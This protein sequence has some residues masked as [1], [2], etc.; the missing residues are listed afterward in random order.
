LILNNPV[1]SNNYGDPFRTPLFIN[2]E[3][4]IKVSA[5]AVSIGTKNASISLF[6]NG[7]KKIETNSDSL[8]YKFTV[9]EKSN[10][11]TIAGKDTANSTDTVEFAVLVNPPIK[12][13]HLP[14]NNE[15]GINYNSNTSVTLALFAPYK[16]FVYLIGDF[17][18]W[19]VDTAYFMKKDSVKADSV[20]WWLTINNL[21]PG[22]EYSF[23]YFVDGNLR[24][25]D[26]FSTKVL[27]PANDQYISNTVYPNLKPYPYNKTSEIVSVLET[28][29]PVYNWK[30]TSFKKP[31]KSNLI[32]Y[33][34][35]VRDFVSTR[36]FKTVEDTLS[37]LKRLGVNAIEF[38]PVMEFE[39]N[40]SWGYNPDFQMALDKYYGTPDAFKS[41]IDKAHSMGIA[42][43]LDIVLNH[44]Y[45]QSPLARL[46]WDTS[47]NRPAA[48][49]PWFN[50]VSPNP[51]YSFGNDFNHES[52][53]TKYFID[54]VNKYWI[55]EY[56]A[57]GFR[58]DFAKG[59]T[60]TY[61][62]GT[63]YDSKRIA[64]MQRMAEKIW[65]IDSTSILILENFVDNAEEKVESGFGFLSWG[66][67]NYNYNEATMGYNQPGHSDL[68]NAYF[69]FR[70]WPKPSLVSY[71]ESHDEERLMYKNEQY[72]NHSPYYNVKLISNGLKRMGEAAAFFLT[73]PGPKMI[74]QFGELGYDYSINYPSL[75]S[76]DRLTAKPVKWEYFN[77]PERQRLYKIFAAIIKLRNSNPV[78]E[79]IQAMNVTDSL[80]SIQFSD[81]SMKVNIIGNFG[82]YQSNINPNFQ[83]PGEWYD[84]LSGDSINVSDQNAL[85]PIAPG[86]YHIYTTVKLPVPDLSFTTAVK[87][88]ESGIITN[89]KL[90]QN[91]PN[92]FNPSTTIE[93]QIPKAGLITLKIFDILGREVETLVNNE[94]KSS[95]DYKVVFSASNL[96]SGIYFYQLKADEFTS[97]KKM[98][99]LK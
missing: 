53:K 94:Y 89:Y 95:G 86:E 98:I 63:P 39:G 60:N 69:G 2:S 81:S 1:I 40:D 28:G 38:M 61:G 11:V 7:V 72:G 59:F 48:N 68:R 52:S 32:I 34:L 19:K 74:W 88:N 99:L 20:I 17:N 79:T 10:L 21:I 65:A 58:F 31:D 42:V 83:Q 80:K 92:P 37:Y 16:K 87:N 73:V 13:E 30:V 82:V 71:M 26:P 43:I 67:M 4:T 6:I 12:I 49:N 41:L 15:L 50:S 90:E 78:F 47:N 76:A 70:G 64:I 33:E 55:T 45:N 46:Y 5:K 9:Q 56:H 54:R 14:S 18:D 93:Y 84:Y 51:A 96:A 66:N 22:K 44:A 23:Q 29:Q 36:W 77:D 57:D 97:A 62:E 27:D 3:D 8:D 25:A 85:I 24:I 75:T 91:F 35:L